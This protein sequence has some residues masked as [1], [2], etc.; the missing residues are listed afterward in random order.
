MTEKAKQLGE[1]NAY[2]LVHDDRLD[3]IVDIGFS[4][5][6]YFAAKAL[7]GMMARPDLIIDH[8]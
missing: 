3:I 8:R 6:E 4:K 7:Q 2:P 5:R 1:Q